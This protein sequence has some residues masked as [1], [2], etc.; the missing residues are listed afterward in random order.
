MA[1]PALQLEHSSEGM[2]GQGLQFALLGGEGF[3]DDPLC[4][5]M[6]TGIGNGVEPVDQLDVHILEVAEAA[7]QEE[8]LPDI[9]ERPL[10]LSLG[11][12]PIGTAG[13]RLNR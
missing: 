10:D 3:G 1:D 4:R 12:G 5:A 2:F 13:P 8:V 11:F 7:G 6:Q 9:A